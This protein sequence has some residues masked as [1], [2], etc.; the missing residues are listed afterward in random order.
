MIRIKRLEKTNE[1]RDNVMQHHAANLQQPDESGSVLSG[2]KQSP[3]LILPP[4]NNGA[5]SK[6]PQVASGRSKKSV[7]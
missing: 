4:I 6:Q 3:S 5:A 1:I 2:G 7:L